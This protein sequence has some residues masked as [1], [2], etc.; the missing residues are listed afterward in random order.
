MFQ[1]TKKQKD[2]L[3]QMGQKYNLRFIILHG[4]HAHGATHM[5]SDLDI[6]VLG[7]KKPSVKKFLAMYSDF[8][9]LFGDSKDRELDFK[10]LHHTDPLFR[11]LTV[12]DGVLLHGD[13][14]EYSEYRAYAFK[15]FIDTADLRN[16]ETIITKKRQA[17]LINLCLT[18]NLLKEKSR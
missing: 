12:R 18:P 1:L 9:D 16:L 14:L 11:Y 3:T 17:Q 13:S 15:D 4:S 2:I 10:T 7:E 5:D 8:S 6:A